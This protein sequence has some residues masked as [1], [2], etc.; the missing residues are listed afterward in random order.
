MTSF[1][2]RLLLILLIL[3][4]LPILL[5]VY[6]PSMR[7]GGFGIILGVIGMTISPIILFAALLFMVKK[8]WK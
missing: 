4:A 7:L 5:H 8:L 1:I 2:K 3:L 6:N